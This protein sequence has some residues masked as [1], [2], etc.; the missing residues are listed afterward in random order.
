MGFDVNQVTG[1]A[2]GF[3]LD[4]QTTTAMRELVGCYKG[5]SF[6]LVNY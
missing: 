6:W 2:I 4:L 1:P 5:I 3:P